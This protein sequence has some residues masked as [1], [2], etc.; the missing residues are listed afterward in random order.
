MRQ[1][2]KF[3][4]T[5]GMDECCQFT[6]LSV[7]SGWLHNMLLGKITCT[8][9]VKPGREWIADELSGE[10]PNIATIVNPD[11]RIIDTIY[12]IGCINTVIAIRVAK[13]KP[14]IIAPPMKALVDLIND[15]EFIPLF[16]SE[17]QNIY[18]YEKSAGLLDENDFMNLLRQQYGNKY[19][20]VMEKYG[21]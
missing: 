13:F 10:F 7:L 20:P 17:I 4:Q 14:N 15:I 12:N 16:E 9:L 3:L 6:S 5:L 19:K 8:I 18:K 2:A 21:I 1:V 11:R